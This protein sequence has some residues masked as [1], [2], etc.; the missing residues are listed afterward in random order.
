MNVSV[1]YFANEFTLETVNST[2]TTGEVR[3]PWL[4]YLQQT[5][6]LD[7]SFKIAS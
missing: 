6:Y 1:K 5:D 3:I 7:Y 4:F 2:T